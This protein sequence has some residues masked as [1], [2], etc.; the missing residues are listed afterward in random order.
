MTKRATYSGFAGFE[1]NDP[2]THELVFEVGKLIVNFGAAEFL[3][4]RLIAMLDEDGTGH[5]AA[6]DKTF[7]QRFRL[8]EELARRQ[9]MPTEILSDIETIRAPVQKLAA[10]RNTIA[11]NPIV[12]HWKGKDVEGK[13]GAFVVIDLKSQKGRDKPIGDTVTLERLKLAVNAIDELARNLDSIAS[14]VQA[15]RGEA[16]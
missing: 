6:L 9:G 7:M 10:F 8:I 3:T 4:Y 13:P 16:A 15:Q 5:T 1:T 14:A 11:H 2:S 12:Q